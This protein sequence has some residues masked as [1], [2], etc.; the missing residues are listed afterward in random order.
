VEAVRYFCLQPSLQ[1][2]WLAYLPGL[3]VA[4]P[5]WRRLREMV[6][7]RLRNYPILLARGGSLGYPQDL[8]RLS[9]R[10]CD[11]YGQ[12]LFDDLDPEVYL[13]PNYAWSE[14]GNDLKALGVTNISYPN[15][16]AR[17]DPYL[18]GPRPRLLEPTFDNDW[19]TRAAG[20]LLRAMRSHPYVP[21]I[22]G[23]IRQMPLIPL[24]DGSLSAN[25][26]ADIYFPDDTKGNAIPTDLSLRIV[27]REA[28][29]NEARQSLFRF[30]DV[31]H[32][33]TGFVINQISARYNRR[34]GITLENSVSH[35]RYLY[36]TL[37]RGMSLDDRIFLMDQQEIPIYRKFVTFGQEIVVDDL[38]FETPGQYGTTQL[39]REIQSAAT[40]LDADD[41]EMHFIHESYIAAVPSDVRNN[42]QSWERWLEDTASVRRI[43][44]FKQSTTSNRLSNLFR[45]IIEF[46][47]EKLIGLLKTY[48]ESYEREITPE[49]V[50]AIE[51]AE[52]PCQGT[53]R[54]FPLK[55]THFPSAELT[56]ICS[57][58]TVS[59]YFGLFLAIPPAWTTA[60]A[61]GWEFLEGFGVGRQP[62][63][64]FFKDV[65]YALTE[66]LTPSQAQRGFF[67]VYEELSARFHGH[68]SDGIT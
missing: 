67:N 28:L 39:A 17:L 32:C 1:Y 33:D 10:H 36:W 42:G 37:A 56:E 65:F 11:R 9:A 4:N 15:L 7:A 13:S 5:F 53:D 44:M 14:H 30:L 26:R 2:K 22:T 54:L 31:S 46:Q 57:R 35:L 52:V 62:D 29:L 61:V 40:R 64:R 12:P 55:S 16:L 18:R 68:A 23:R 60:T 63:L 45:Y 38:Y 49:I 24:S 20:L 3:H 48:W 34:H 59:D 51:N 25:E 8:Q 50:E 19:H 47:S 43:P 21:A 58:A 6:I 41:F 27:G 66:E